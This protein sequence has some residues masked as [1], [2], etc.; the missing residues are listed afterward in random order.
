VLRQAYGIQ[1]REHVL[2]IGCGLG[3]CGNHLPL[4]QQPAIRPAL[5]SEPAGRGPGRPGP[6][7]A[8]DRGSAAVGDPGADRGPGGTQD[9]ELGGV[10]IPSGGFVA[11][12]LG[13]AN[14]DPGRYADPD[15]FDIF[16]GG[17]AAPLVRR[18]DT[19]V[20]GHAPGPAGDADAAERSARP[21]AGLRLDPAFDG[22]HIHGMLF[23]SP[24]NLPVRFDPA[25]RPHPFTGTIVR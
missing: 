11:V 23:R 2:D 5:R 1:P 4:F 16:R 18:R 21:P 6:G 13:A 14:R 8:G 19:Q 25:A 15:A 22:V 7:A 12:S 9:V 20:P 10:R 24:P 17:Q 3:G